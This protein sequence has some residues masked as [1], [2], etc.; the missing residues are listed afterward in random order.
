MAIHP[1]FFQR[2]MKIEIYHIGPHL[3][4]AIVGSGVGF[5]VRAA[6]HGVV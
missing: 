1:I 6:K 2:A 5:R 4:E 3:S